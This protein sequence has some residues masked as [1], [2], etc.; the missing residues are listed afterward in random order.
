M[1]AVGRLLVAALLQGFQTIVAH[2]P[3]NA[4]PPDSKR[5]FGEFGVHARCAIGLAGR[6]ELRSNM[7]QQDHVL[8]VPATG[9][10][11]LPGKYPLSLT[12]RTSHRRFTGNS[13]FA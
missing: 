4:M 12:P 10:T 1:T 2:E 7:R 6:R 5:L 9:R 3:S 11:T 13:F 8:T